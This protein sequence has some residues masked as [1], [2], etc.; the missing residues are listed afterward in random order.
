M[1]TSPLVAFLFGLAACGGGTAPAPVAHPTEGGNGGET[2]SDDAAPPTPCALLGGEETSKLFGQPPDNA[3][4][5]VVTLEDLPER[6]PQLDGQLVRTSGTIEAV[7]HDG[8]WIALHDALFDG[9]GFAVVREPSITIPA[10]ARGCA[11]TLEGNLERVVVQE[12]DAEAQKREGRPEETFAEEGPTPQL[13]VM[14]LEARR[15]TQ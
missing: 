7:G 8:K 6:A 1:R 14:G 10:G 15:P 2:A 13:V 9:W 3:R 4:A 11:V 5:V 12:N